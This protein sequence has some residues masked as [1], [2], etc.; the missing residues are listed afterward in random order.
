[1]K[2]LD[3][4]KAF[5]SDEQCLAYLEGTGGPI[6]AKLHTHLLQDSNNYSGSRISRTSP[7]IPTYEKALPGRLGPFGQ[8]RG[9]YQ[10]QAFDQCDGDMSATS[11]RLAYQKVKI[12]VL[13]RRQSFF[14]QRSDGSSM[15]LE[16]K[17][18][19]SVTTLV[20]SSHIRSSFQQQADGFVILVSAAL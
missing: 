16:R 2:L 5:H 1:M 14:Q 18:Q 9:N 10:P 7:K 6:G 11:A 13:S 17:R 15:I 8:V 4:T 20:C 19:W 12:S 3:V